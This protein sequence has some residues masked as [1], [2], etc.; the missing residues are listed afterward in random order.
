[1]AWSFVAAGTQATGANPT[2]PLPSYSAGNLLLLVV[3]SQTANTSATPTGYTSLSSLSGGT[4]GSTYFNIY[5]KIAG[6]SETAPN[7]SIIATTTIAVILSYSGVTSLDV[8]GAT[9]NAHTTTATTTST[10]TTNANDLVLSIYC[11]ESG[12]FG[13]YTWTA[14]S[15]TTARV[16]SGGATGTEGLLICDELQTTAGATTSRTATISSSKQWGAVTIA[17]SVSAI[18]NISN[19]FAFF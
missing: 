1:M 13:T 16:N 7:L 9:S 6:S 8:V 15:G 5:Y 17:F 14:P 3:A 18:T 19:F 2:V 4:G 11:G 10:T 12:A